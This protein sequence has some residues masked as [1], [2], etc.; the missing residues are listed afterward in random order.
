M[1]A[2]TTDSGPLTTTSIRALRGND[3]TTKHTVEFLPNEAPAVRP[4]ANA[5]QARAHRTSVVLAKETCSARQLHT[6]CQN[7]YKL[8]V[9]STGPAG[10]A[11]G[12]PSRS[13]KGNPLDT[14]HSPVDCERRASAGR[15]WRGTAQPLKRWTLPDKSSLEAT[16]HRA[17]SGLDGW[18]TQGLLQK[19]D[20]H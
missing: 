6:Q 3:P 16:R 8:P 11:R 19:T 12:L 5:T 17:P 4:K 9:R 7:R 1:A 10:T 14:W 18:H 2:A 15:T 20:T 13:S